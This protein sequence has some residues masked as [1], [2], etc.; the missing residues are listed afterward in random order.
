MFFGSSTQAFPPFDSGPKLA[1]RKRTGWVRH[2]RP[3]L[4]TDAH[5]ARR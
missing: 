1:H 5:E 4:A 2:T 3:A